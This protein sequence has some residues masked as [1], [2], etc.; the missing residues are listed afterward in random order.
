M[1]LDEFAADYERY[2]RDHG[3]RVTRREPYDEGD[4]YRFFVEL[5]DDPEAGHAC[6]GVGASHGLSPYLVLAAG[7]RTVSELRFVAASTNG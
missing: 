7:E 6:Y 5:R 2:L 3:V 4:G 1:T